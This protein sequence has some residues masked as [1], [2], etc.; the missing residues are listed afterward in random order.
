MTFLVHPIMHICDISP[1]IEI[2]NFKNLLK[3]LKWFQL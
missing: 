2:W 1:I 3:G